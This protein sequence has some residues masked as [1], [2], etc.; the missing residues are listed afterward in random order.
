M[1]SQQRG[2]CPGRRLSG[3]EPSTLIAQP[4]VSL[5]AGQRE[6]SA[7]PK[8]AHARPKGPTHAAIYGRENKGFWGTSELASKGLGRTRHSTNLPFPSPC[9][10][11]PIHARREV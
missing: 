4:L 2:C 5:L 11:F 10:S 9:L 1:D 3:P 6:P 7:E 8:L